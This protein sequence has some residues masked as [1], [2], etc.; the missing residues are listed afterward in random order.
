MRFTVTRVDPDESGEA[1]NVIVRVLGL[2]H[3][4]HSTVC[5]SHH[6]AAWCIEYMRDEYYA[7]A[8]APS[9]KDLVLEVRA[10]AMRRGLAAARVA[11]PNLSADILRARWLRAEPGEFVREYGITRKQA[12]DIIRAWEREDFELMPEEEDSLE[13]YA[14]ADPENVFMYRPGGVC[15]AD[16]VEDVRLSSDHPLP[17]VVRAPS[18]DHPPSAAPLTRANRSARRPSPSDGPR[19]GHASGRCS[20]GTSSPSAW[21]QRIVRPGCGRCLPRRG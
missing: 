9:P 7:G 20:M 17:W 6:L 8:R 15:D 4:G 3:T 12:R 16:G 2:E 13:A 14:E 5:I 21:T 18:S 11:E 19:R 10:E 1:Q